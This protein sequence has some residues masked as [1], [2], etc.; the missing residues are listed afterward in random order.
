MKFS[1]SLRFNANS[2][3][4]EHYLKYDHLKKLIYRKEVEETKGLS[5]NIPEI[6]TRT[7]LGTS[8]TLLRRTQLPKR[9][10][11]SY[12]VSHHVAVPMPINSSILYV[13]Q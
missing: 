3:W 1:H 11:S 13:T 10:C 9:R 5:L 6:Q 8:I 7:S 4:N 2:E 12:D